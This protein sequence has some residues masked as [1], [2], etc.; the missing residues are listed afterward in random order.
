VEFGQ[1][2]QRKTRIVD[3]FV[4]RWVRLGHPGREQSQGPIRLPDDEM[5]ASRMPLGADDDD[6]FAASRMV[7]IGNPRLKSQTPGSMMLVRRERVNLT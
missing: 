3:E 4:R 2:L 6:E 1:P 5:I 7:G